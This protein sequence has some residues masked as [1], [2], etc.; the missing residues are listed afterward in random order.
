MSR[1]SR[2]CPPL[3]WG[4]EGRPRSKSIPRAIHQADNRLNP[5]KA[6]TLAKGAPLSDRF[7]QPVS[8]K[9]PLK[10]LTHRLAARIVQGSQFQHIAT[11]LI[12][13]RQGFTPPSLSH[14]PPPLEVHGP[15]LVGGLPSA[16]TAEPPSFQRPFSHSA[17]LS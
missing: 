16:S 1:W 3:S 5:C 12:A 11:E 9:N 17:R 13:D 14:S 15:H 8:L 2:S 6:C 7:R 10:G 4:W